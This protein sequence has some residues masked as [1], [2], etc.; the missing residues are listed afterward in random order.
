MKILLLA[1]YGQLGASSRL[2]YFQYIPYLQSQGID[3]EPAVLFDDTYVS[4]LMRTGRR[5]LIALMAAYLR[6]FRQLSRLKKYDL[7]WMEYEA[8]PWLPYWIERLFLKAHVP[9]V[10]EY[11]DAIFHRYDLHASAWVRR[12]L[13]NKIPDLMRRSRLV[14]VGNDYLAARAERAGAARIVRIPTAIDMD[15]YV[16]E[17]KDGGDFTVGWIGS[18]ITVPYLEIIK[19]ALIRLAAS[20][21]LKLRV[22]GAEAP[23]WPGVDAISIPW[24]EESEVHQINKFDVGVMPLPDEPWERGKCGY[25]LIQYM[26]CGKPVVASPVGANSTIVEAGMEGFLADSVEEWVNHLQNLRD[27]KAL[28]ETLGQAGRAKVEKD[29]CTRVIAPRLAAALRQVFER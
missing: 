23:Q 28:R 27:D 9:Y 16:P 13:G 17:N 7:I 4:G 18:P 29:Y 6:R 24:S 19:P 2:R 11:D 12:I 22:I 21:P 20:G 14:I 10:V 26:A 5:S 1:R 8:F 15:R 25:K 3:V